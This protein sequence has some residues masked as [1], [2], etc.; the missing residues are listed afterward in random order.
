MEKKRR[1]IYIYIPSLFLN[2]V[3]SYIINNIHYVQD[4]EKTAFLKSSR[5]KKRYFVRRVIVY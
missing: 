5:S 3:C 4:V 1:Y 2:K